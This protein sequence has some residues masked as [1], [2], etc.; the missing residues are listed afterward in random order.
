MRRVFLKVRT[1]GNTVPMTTGMLV[2]ADGNNLAWAGFHALRRPMGADTPE[3]KAR[4]ALLGFTQSLLGIIIRGGEPP[5]QRMI[6]A[7]PGAISGAAVVFDE[8]RP[9][10]RRAIF[11]G[12]QLGREGDPN[13][14]DNEPFVLDA[15][16]QFSAAAVA[17]PIAVLRGTNTEADDLMA[18]LV[19]QSSAPHVRI[20]S[21]DKDFLQLIDERVSVYAPVKRLVIDAAN[22]A[23]AVSPSGTD[24]VPAT[25]PRERYLDYRA[26]SGDASDN[27]P[28][29]AGVGPL[30]AAKLLAAAPI[31]TYFAE[32]ARATA[33]LGRRN[34]KLEATL[35]SPEARTQFE[36]NRSLMDLREAA[37]RFP[38]L[39]SYTRTGTWDEAAFRDW[40]KEQRIAGLEVN[41]ACRAME[42]LAN[43]AA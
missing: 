30:T 20:A 38:D 23:A 28:G 36:R 18:A 4:A 41:A 22:F 17:L 14:M 26:A 40:V 11:P 35:A 29:I 39:A 19:L 13:F 42:S 27:L 34:Q 31:Q 1:A 16:A 21:T 12:Y 9:L 32:P 37:G 2:V 5:A 15:I 7:P 8:G 43:A 25:F 6:E 33:A 24:G 3:K 10:R